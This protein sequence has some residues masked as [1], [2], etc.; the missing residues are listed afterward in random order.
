MGTAK[1]ELAEDSAAY[2]SDMA[3]RY[4]SLAMAEQHQAQSDLFATIAADYAELA[5]TVASVPRQ[6]A[7]VGRS[8]AGSLA[9]WITWAGR[10]RHP[11]STAL[12]SPLGSAM[13]SP[14]PA[15]PTA[16]E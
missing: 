4:Q 8:D 7:A 12:N 3:R 5:A 6:A 9:R 2:F 14:L 16:A 1:V 10:W 11:P 13:A 15:G